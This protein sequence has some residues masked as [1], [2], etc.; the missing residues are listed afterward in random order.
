MAGKIIE[1]K[2]DQYEE[3]VLNGGKVVVDF[4]STECPPCDALVA[5]FAPLSE[6]YGDDV[7]FV[8]IFRQGNKELAAELQVQSSPTLLFFE[9][10]KEVSA[11]LSGGILRSAIVEGLEKMLATERAQEIKAAQEKSTEECDVLILGAGPAGL[12]AGIYAA[13]AQLKTIVVD[14]G[15]AGGQVSTTHLVSNW[16]GVVE[17]INGFMLMHYMDEQARAN[18]V[19][20]RLA[21]ELTDIDLDNKTV[22]ID[23]LETIS[24]KK[25]ILA[26]GASP[27]AIGI[28]GEEEYRGKGISY[29]ATCDGK[30]MDGKEIIVIGGGNS[31]VEEALF[32]DRFA[33]KMTVIHQFDQLQ[34]NKVA[35]EKLMKLG[36]EGKVDFKFSHEPREFIRN[37][38]GTMTVRIEN[39]K[40]KEMTDVTADGV[41]VFVG[42]KPNLDG[43]ENLDMD[44]FGYV[45][46]D[47]VQ[48]TSKKDVFAAGD[49]ASKRFR[50][51]TVAT[52]EG[53]VAAIQ[54]GMEIE[55][56]K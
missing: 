33:K 20:Y 43:L 26:T 36:E 19:V 31:A 45:K 2:A 44:D 47:T 3:V 10:G 27:N 56:E 49:M 17:P 6:L 37:D 50:Q 23:G 22:E 38:D 8:K 25:I 39:L 7:K 16:P 51:I 12:T 52:A 35:Q 15:L 41:F 30:Y 46:T 55:Q 40:T 32:L 21:V 5:K 54:A 1:I 34:A 28:P 11:R 48:H 18:G 14:K 42:M 24:A 29:C 9:D 13:Q 53:T 4:Y